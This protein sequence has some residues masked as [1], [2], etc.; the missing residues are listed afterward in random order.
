[1]GKSVKEG[2]MPKQFIHSAFGESIPGLGL[3]IG[4]SKEHGHVQVA[5][6]AEDGLKLEE[7][8]E[9]NGWFVTMDRAGINAAIKALRKARDD[10]FGRDE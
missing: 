7:T 2:I 9:G 3:R 8:P 4:W 1:M 10:A 6:V 5:S